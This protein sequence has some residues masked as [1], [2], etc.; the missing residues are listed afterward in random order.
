[1]NDVVFWIILS[2]GIA[3]AVRNFVCLCKSYK[4][5]KMIDKDMQR[6]QKVISQMNIGKNERNK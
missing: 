1:M 6:L 5:F 3:L 2:I 4:K